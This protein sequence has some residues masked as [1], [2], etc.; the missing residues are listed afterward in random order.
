M[1]R[2][3]PVVPRTRWASSASVPSGPLAERRERTGTP[4]TSS[5]RVEVLRSACQRYE[6]DAACVETR[7]DQPR[8][9]LLSGRSESG[10]HREPWPSGCEGLRADLCACQALACTATLGTRNEG[11]LRGVL[12]ESDRARPPHLQASPRR[13]GAPRTR[14]AMRALDPRPSDP[15]KLSTEQD[16]LTSPAAFT[17]REL[18]T[19][20]HR[21]RS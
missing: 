21:D 11:G 1:R 4:A 14:W 15:A 20:R 19:R 13:P 8:W 12:G 17:R 18:G 10:N 6:H 2:S 3:R 9:L 16:A 7:A 5:L